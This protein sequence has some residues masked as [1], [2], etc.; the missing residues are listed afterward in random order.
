MFIKKLDMLSPPITLY[1]K[2]ENN[3]S[4]IF[5]GILTVISYAI[6]LAA[7]IYYALEFINKDNP[8]AYFYNRYMEDVG[9]FPINASSMFHF[10]QVYSTS[11]NTPIPTD[12][13]KIE[14]VG[15]DVTIDNYENDTDLSKYNHW[16]YGNCNNETDTEGI[17]YLI[18]QDLFTECACI[19][20]YYN[21]ETKKYY[22]SKDE[23]FKWP[24]IMHG[25]SHPDVNYYGVVVKK[26]ENTE[27]RIKNFGQ[28][29]P[30]EEISK[31]LE[32]IYINFRIVDHY[33]DVINYKEPF[34]KYL[35]AIT[36]GIFNGTYTINHLNFNPAFMETHNGIFF[37]NRVE[38]IAYSFTTNEKITSEAKNISIITGFYFWI[39]NVQQYFEREYRRLQDILSDIGGIGSIILIIAEGINYLVSNFIILL[40]TERLILNIELNNSK[41]VDKK[42][43]F[44]RTLNEILAPPRR[45]IINNSDIL[46]N[47]RQSSNYEGTMKEDINIIK[48]NNINIDNENLKNQFKK[49]NDTLNRYLK[50]KYNTKKENSLN[51]KEYRNEKIENI[52]FSNKNNEEEI[53]ESYKIPSQNNRDYHDKIKFS[54]SYEESIKQDYL[55]DRQQYNNKKFYHINSEIKIFNSERGNLPGELIPK[56]NNK[57]KNYKVINNENKNKKY[58]EN[59]DKYN[60]SDIDKNKDNIKL[61][62]E[63]NFNWFNY[64]CYMICCGKNNPKIKY[65]ENLRTQIISEENII[66]NHLDIYKLVKVCQIENT[67]N[68][69]KN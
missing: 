54:H 30:E 40:D 32:H 28:C 52:I 19:R 13:N 11:T 31:Y 57:K 64:I 62:N 34:T 49:K 2:G 37:D 4:S 7:G 23:N 8:T 58:L 22:D 5:S 44:Y 36:N 63:H 67:N 51:I 61:Y 59:N 27:L 1:Y 41:N 9:T 69:L 12:F 38:E 21:K 45:F 65:Y 48:N 10:L 47:S 24:F 29:S 14:I 35:Y 16:I 25:A 6:I 20:K 46:N 18:N 42:P 56:I 15:I 60:N 55:K 39:Q 26:C 33:T 50:N 43:T 17:N 66:Q 3:H 53:N 68:L